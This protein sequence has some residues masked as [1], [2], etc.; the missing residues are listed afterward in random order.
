MGALYCES[1]EQR[2]SFR[3]QAGVK[4]RE[5]LAFY[6]SSVAT[7]SLIGIGSQSK[8]ASVGKVWS[9]MLMYDI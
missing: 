8:D 2:Q 6:M 3:D 4:E 7:S 9:D 5:H 1:R